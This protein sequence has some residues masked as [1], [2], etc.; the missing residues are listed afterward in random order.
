VSYATANFTFGIASEEKPKADIISW[1]SEII[2]D[3]SNCPQ[4]LKLTLKGKH[5]DDN[6]KVKIGSK[7][8]NNVEVKNSKELTAKFCLT[9]LKKT[10]Q[11]ISVKNPDTDAKKADK[12]IDLSNLSFTSSGDSLDMNTEE[13]IKNI[14]RILVK[15]KLLNKDSITGIYGPLT[16]QAVKEFQKI[17]HL[18]ET[19]MVGPKTKSELGRV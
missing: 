7:E 3:Q 4:K 17:H 8:S 12:K 13:G 19:G 10:K 14:Q 1:K 16:T 9:K 6:A 2:T 11:T 18:P 15:L 5:F